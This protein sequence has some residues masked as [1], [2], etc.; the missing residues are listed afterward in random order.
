VP[1]AAFL[2]AAN[3]KALLHVARGLHVSG[4]F[5]ELETNPNL[6]QLATEA[7]SVGV[8]DRFVELYGEQHRSP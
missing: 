4:F 2:P 6:E 3:R 7:E 8:K 1:L 5:E